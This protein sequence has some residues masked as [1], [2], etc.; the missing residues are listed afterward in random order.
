MDYKQQLFDYI[1]AHTD[2]MVEDVIRLCRI[3][4][5]RS[6]YE[7]GKPYGEGP[8]Q[9]LMAAMHLCERYG[10]ATKNYDNY[11]MTA[12][13]NAGAPQLDILAHMDVVAPGD[14]WTVTKPFDPV[15]QDGKIYGRG[16]SDDKGPAMAALYAMRAVKELGLPVTKN[17]RLILGSDEECGSSDIVHYY[18]VEQEAPMTFSPDAEFPVT[19]VEKGQFRCELRAEFPAAAGAGAGSASAGQAAILKAFRGGTTTNIV[20]GKAE[21]EVCGLDDDLIRTEAE[22]VTK[23][24]GVKF[25]IT[26]MLGGLRIHAEG[27]GAHASKPE[28]GKNAVLALLQLLNR[29]PFVESAQR[30]ILKKLEKCFPYGDHNGDALGIHVS[31]EI[32]G[33]TTVSLNI[34]DVSETKLYAKF[35][36]RTS[37]AANEENTVKK[38]EALLQEQG[39]TVDAGYNPPHV[40]PEESPFI[41]TLLQAYETVTGLK[42]RCAAIGGGTY[43]HHLKNGVAFGAVGETTDTHMHGA[44]EFMLIEELKQAA[45]I[46]AL[47]IAELCR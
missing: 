45:K 14:G 22:A 46:Y 18:A 7:A 37:I 41:Q 30:D 31:D 16:T 11:V 6:S 29:L 26:G 10:F 5:V 47:S 34:V 17:C 35:D 40:V 9:A 3:D 24:T 42:G 12:D 25:N 28:G 15:V 33:S 32:S 39:F 1:D 2:E 13:L 19:N 43:V 23:A 21:A 38:A 44:D 4:S 36:S 27:Q 8:Y 20:P